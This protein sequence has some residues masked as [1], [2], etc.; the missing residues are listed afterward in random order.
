MKNNLEQQFSE[1]LVITP[2]SSSVRE[3][4]SVSIPDDLLFDILSR[5]PGKSLARFRCV[6]KFWKS[7]LNRPDF[8]ELYLTVGRRRILFFFTVNGESFVFSSPQPPNHNS[9]LV[10]T[11]AMRLMAKYFPTRQCTELCGLVFLRRKKARVICNPVTGESI[12]LPRVKATGVGKSYFGFDP[13]S[14]QFKVLCMT[15]SRYG[16][17]NT[18]RILTLEN[19]KKRIWRTIPDPVLPHYS[20][21]DEICI[22]GVLYYVAYFPSDRSKCMVCFDFGLEKFSFIKLK[23]YMNYSTRQLTLFNY[24]GKLGVHQYIGSLHNERSGL[25][26]LEDVGE[27]KWSK[28]ICILPD[29]V[30]RDNRFVGMTATGEIVFSS[31]YKPF[32][33]FFYNIENKTYTR[34]HIQGFEELLK[35]FQTFVQ[36]FLD[37]VEDLKLV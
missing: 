2:S 20:I 8:T 5:V 32:Y 12:S 31:W 34:I 3:E 15:W 23:P 9:T 14:K 19:G 22:N 35:P 1:G 27:H 37:F 28:R 4:N 21:D 36:I 18:H 16:T 30:Y 25:Y 6:S 29:I 11:N 10:A 17:P 26:V 24:K 33:I 13:I 7:L